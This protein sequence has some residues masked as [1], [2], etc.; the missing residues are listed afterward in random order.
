[1]THRVRASIMVEMHETKR[2]RVAA[3][4]NYLC[5]RSVVDMIIYNI[6]TDRSFAR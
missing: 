2:I 5:E 6:T 4:L 3:Q 1:M